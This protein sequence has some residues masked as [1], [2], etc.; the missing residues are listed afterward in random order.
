MYISPPDYAR[1]FQEIKR[2]SSS[3]STCKL[4]IFVSCLDIDSICTGKILSIIF[5]KNLIQ[6]QLIPVVGYTDLK[7]HYSKLDA[8]ISNVILIGCGAML[9]LESFFDINS[10]DYI[11][12]DL[13]PDINS[14]SH[15][16]QNDPIFNLKKLKRKIFILDGH[17]PWNL[18]NLFGSNMIVCFDDGYIDS[19]L[20]NEKESYEK[21]CDAEEVSSEESEESEEEEEEEEEEITILS[22]D[23][24]SN[25]KRQ[26][27][28]DQLKTLKRQ[29]RKNISKWEDD[30]S[31]YYNQGTTI[32]TSTT[33]T[34][35]ALLGSIGEA[36]IENLWLSIIGT[37][38]L[39]NHY[40]EVYDKIQPLFKDEVIRLNPFN[41]PQ[42]VTDNKTA[43]T[44]TLSIEKD[45]H[46]F[47]LRHWTLYDSFFYSSHVNS[48]LNL[49]TED[50]KKRLHK[51]FAKMGVSLSIA[52]QKWLYMD[53]NIKKKLPI[54]FAEYL[55]SYGL[56]GIVR[57]GFIRTFGFAGQL[58]AMECVESLTALLECD[59][60]LLEDTNN[61][62]NTNK[63]NDD[64]ETTNDD[65]DINSK[66][67]EKEKIWVNNFWSSW[68]ALS[69]N[70]G[71]SNNIKKL[72]SSMNNSISNFKKLKGLDL[73]LQGLDHAK[74]IQQIIFK[75]GMSLLERKLIKNLRLY[76]LCV[77]NDGSIPDLNI[78]NNPLILS[79]LGSWL[80]ENITELEFSNFDE[81]NIKSLKPLVV[82]SLDVSSDTYLVIG[83][84]P[85]YPRGMNNATRARLLRK[86]KE[87]LGEKIDNNLID[88][89]TLTT[90]L[91]TFSI[92]F[93][94]TA[95]TSGA[96]VRIDSFDSSVI[97][98]RKDDLSP[99]L[100]KLTLSG[101]I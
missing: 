66:I 101:L 80:L 5:K 68:D 8:E 71:S 22:D 90:R 34:I 86:Q 39:D 52:Q 47:L 31:S 88:E 72:N 21:L 54:I 32:I 82:A 49:W 76:R 13:P 10:N 3:H 41:N 27:I 89:S 46:L 23:E 36:N 51:L 63:I 93:Q 94:K 18:D 12:D 40:P 64:N 83:L 84:A 77:L 48:K 2:T 14:L 73:L 29:R 53:I 24:T 16:L 44:T 25:R 26:K 9:D 81:N 6:Y 19:S 56:E 7:N 79:K 96:K 11:I 70:N 30:I 43:D 69:M 78:F 99:F 62:N 28:E 37:S 75:T 35:Y 55:P 91:N 60:R 15:D 58:S 4:I 45:Y 92:A 33:A 87:K 100:E 42:L 61:T 17:R 85:K 59:K 57:D 65:D 98:I 1:V 74:Q 67:A 97:E 95:T 20:T 50:G 38:S